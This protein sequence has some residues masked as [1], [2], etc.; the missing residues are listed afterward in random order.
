MQKLK[1][2]QLDQTQYVNVDTTTKEG[3][4][5]ASHLGLA[6][7]HLA[8]IIISPHFHLVSSQ[9]FSLGTPGHM[10]ALFRYPVDRSLSMY[11]YLARASWDPHYIL[12]LAKMSVEQ[13]ATSRYIENNWVTRFLVFKP[14]GKLTHADY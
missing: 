2:F 13:Y 14:G 5:R 9:I 3:I 1:L 12:A 10:F 8:N 11:H 7:S 6:S 4:Q